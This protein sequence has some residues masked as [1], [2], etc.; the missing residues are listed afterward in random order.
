MLSTILLLVAGERIP[1]KSAAEFGQMDPNGLAMTIIAMGVVFSSLIVLYLS[2]KYI[3]R[4][5]NLDIK[6]YFRKNHPAVETQEAVEEISGETMAAISLAIH[7]YTQQMQ[8][9]DDAVITIRNVSKTYSPWSSKIYGLRK[10]P[11]S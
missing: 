9:M 2:F 11:N 4:L 6:K 3:A 7:L 5:Y 8:G 1:G 10:Y